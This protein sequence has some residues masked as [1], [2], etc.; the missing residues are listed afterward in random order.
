MCTLSEHASDATS[1]CFVADPVQAV[2]RD[3]EPGLTY[4]VSVTLTN[5]SGKRSALRI[6]EP[7]ADLADVLQVQMHPPGLL[8]AGLSCH[9]RLKFKPKRNEDISTSLTILT[10]LGY[11]ALPVL[12]L[13]KRADVSLSAS[14]MDFGTCVVGEVRMR[15]IEL[16]NSGALQVQCRPHYA[17]QHMQCRGPFATLR[18]LD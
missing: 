11:L 15:T 16:R 9:M 4:C 14:Q 17:V 13:R 18:C 3:F 5:T 6:L 12:C 1:A 10:D 7:L 2:F 8:S